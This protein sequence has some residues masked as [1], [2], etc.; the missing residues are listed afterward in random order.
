MTARHGVGE[1]AEIDA[2]RVLL[3]RL[4]VTA[5]QLL[6]KEAGPVEMPTFDDYIGRVAQAVSPGTLRV[7]DTYWR[8]VS[9]VWGGRRLNEPTPLEIKQL[10]ERVKATVVVRRNARGGRTAAEH[11]IS[12]LRCIY[13]FA[14]A[15]GL[16]LERDNPAMRV[17]K[18]D[19]WPAPGEHC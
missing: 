14:V 11:L 6:T 9:E 4:G 7:Y 17:A 13:R 5:E 19:G 15:D 10:A 12:A 16:L 1:S 8:R 18:P 3:A 2:A